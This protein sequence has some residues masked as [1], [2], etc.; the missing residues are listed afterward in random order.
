[1]IRRWPIRIRLTVAFTLMM[2]LVLA[3]AAIG[4]VSNSRVSLDE[5]ITESLHYRLRDVQSAAAIAAPILTGGRDTAEQILDGGHVVASSREVTG[6]S[7][8][9]PSESSTAEHG[10]IMVE[11]P[12]AGTLPGPVRIAAAPAGGSRVAVAAVSL[13]DRDGAVADLGEEL[14]VAFPLVLVAAAAGAYLL[15]AGSLRPVERMRA[16]AAAITADDPEQRLPLPASQDEIS[17]LGAT[18]NDLLA[19]LHA[20]L[21]RERQFVADASHELR[22]PLSLLITELEL[23]VQRPRPREELTAA[24]H[25]ALEETERLSRLAQ[26]LLLL[27]RSD[28]TSTQHRASAVELRP[29]LKSIVDRHVSC[30]E[31][32][33]ALEC[34]PGLTAH[35]SR[36][37]VDR[38]VSNLLDNAIQHALA[39]I[40]IRAQWTDNGVS[41]EVCDHGP[42][43]DPEFLPHAFDRF[44]RADTARTSGG[45]GLG[46][47]ITAA[48]ARRNGGHVIAANNDGAGAVFTLTLPGIAAPDS[49]SE[50]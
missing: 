19:R 47:S 4:T 44:T 25:S 33:V 27:A 24:L 8:L 34:P 1:M 42:G 16:R 18:F 13:A 35:A 43:L 30:G 41:I 2:A 31:F 49:Q 26:D 12:R 6:Q 9:N 40:M 46:L 36:E 50:A 10:L 23:A 22:T 28:H 11:H 38:A 17:R 7:M 29:L 32:Q 48:L 45:A 20:A 3:G 15:A 39:P 37:D 5:S 21:S 14:G